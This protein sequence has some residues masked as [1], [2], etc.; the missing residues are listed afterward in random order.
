MAGAFGEVVGI[1]GH[2]IL[3]EPTTAACRAGGDHA[4]TKDNTTAADAEQKCAPDSIAIFGGDIAIFRSWLIRDIVARGWRVIACGP[5][6]ADQA[7]SLTRLGAEY[8]AIAI[9]RTGLSPTRDLKSVFSIARTLRSL[10]PE[11]FLSFHTKYNVIGPLAARLAGVPRIYALVAGLGYAFSPGAELKRRLIRM[12]L[13]GAL[14]LSLRCCSGVFVQN[15]DDLHLVW[16]A[17]WVAHR[18]P[19]VQLAGTGVDIDE[20]P[21]VAPSDGPLRVLLIARLIREKGIA[22]YVEAARLVRRHYPDCNFSILGPFVTNPGAISPGAMEAWHREGIVTFLGRTGDVRPFLQACS[23]LVL[24]SYYREGIPKII[25]EAMAT[26]RAIVTCDVP[27]CRE[28][29]TNGLNGFLV[30]PKNPEVLAEAVE[31]FINDPSL[32]VTMG[33]QSR[34]LTEERFDVRNVNAKMMEVMRIGT[35]RTTFETQ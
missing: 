21:Y 30:P 23:I 18:T 1:R 26:G 19:V 10:E 11:V 2:V 13:S 9:D 6:D 4:M 31:C 14:R 24:P 33:L 5:D 32:L 3:V 27:G 35:R 20:F 15:R 34:R 22:E 29:V 8:V 28:A 12:V 7:Q 16:A 25:L 17:G